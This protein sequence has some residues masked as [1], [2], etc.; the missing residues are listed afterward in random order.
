MLYGSAGRDVLYSR[1]GEPD[2]LGGGSQKDRG[3][4]D[5]DIDMVKRIEARL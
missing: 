3:T 4:W 2:T 1:E 5:R